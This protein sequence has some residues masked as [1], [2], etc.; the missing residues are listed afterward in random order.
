MVALKSFLLLSLILN[1]ETMHKIFS[2]DV[3]CY[4]FI[5]LY[6]GSKT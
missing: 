6:Y 5:E 2:A 1:T 4:D 3:F